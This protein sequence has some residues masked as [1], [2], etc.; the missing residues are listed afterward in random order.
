MRLRFVEPELYRPYK[1][2]INIPFGRAS[3]PVLSVI[4]A[5][6]IGSVF[7]QLLF[8]NIEQ[9][10]WIYVGW[11]FFGVL[12]FV[13]YRKYRNKALWEPIEVPPPPDREVAHERLPLPRADRIRLGRRERV[14]A[15]AAIAV[16]HRR[17]RTRFLGL[18]LLIERHGRLRLVVSS[19]IFLA[20][21]T[22]AVLADLSRFDP[23]GPGLGWSPGVILIAGLS[24]LLIVRSSAER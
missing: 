8:Q 19:L 6:A 20:V 1:M 7:T 5:L 10:T 23:F 9:S 3:I 2:P 4:G 14:K 16:E 12:A 22:A 18:Q 13:G 21:C 17:G 11:L 24:L 15:R